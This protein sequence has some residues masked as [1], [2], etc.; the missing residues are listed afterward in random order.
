MFWLLCV[1][2]HIFMS[3]P[4][5]IKNKQILNG[6]TKKI[7][8]HL[9]D[10][11][12]LYLLPQCHLTVHVSVQWAG[13]LAEDRG[14]QVFS[15]FGWLPGPAALRLHSRTSLVFVGWLPGPDSILLTHSAHSRTS[16]SICWLTLS[17]SS[18]DAVF[19]FKS[20]CWKVNWIFR[21]WQLS[22]EED[23]VRWTCAHSGLWL[24]LS[25]CRL[26]KR[27]CSIQQ[28]ADK[29]VC[30]DF[31]HPALNH[32]HSN[33]SCFRRTSYC[34]DNPGRT[35]QSTEDLILFNALFPVL[36]SSWQGLFEAI[37]PRVI[38]RACRLLVLEPGTLYLQPVFV[39]EM[40]A[41]V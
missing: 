39:P 2:R 41:V 4:P 7:N 34:D 36:K 16:L 8:P 29:A 35:V 26:H 23:V 24:L 11:C 32:W 10:N 21:D 30:G 14:N 31:P 28:N 37:N 27:K 1:A 20:T 38:W 25:P 17:F 6:K 19:I 18:R 22:E 15:Y 33:K 3:P 40:L 5:S 12:I 13:S 9:C